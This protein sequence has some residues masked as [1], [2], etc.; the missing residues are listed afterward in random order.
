LLQLLMAAFVLLLASLAGLSARSLDQALGE[1]LDLRGRTLDQ[2][3]KAAE[4]FCAQQPT[5]SLCSLHLEWRTGGTWTSVCAGEGWWAG[6]PRY[7]RIS[8]RCSGAGIHRLRP[9]PPLSFVLRR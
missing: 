2:P 9:L 6:P 7:Y 5:S 1:A 8:A 3:G 4:R